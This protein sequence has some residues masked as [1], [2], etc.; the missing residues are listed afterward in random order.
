MRALTAPEGSS[1]AQ[2]GV[3]GD[4][5]SKDTFNKKHWRYRKCYKCGKKGHPTLN[6]KNKK[7]KQKR[8]LENPVVPVIRIA[9]ISSIPVDR[10]NK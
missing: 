3:G 2:R 5:I 4:G 10:A 7:D 6:C 8:I 1:F 9:T